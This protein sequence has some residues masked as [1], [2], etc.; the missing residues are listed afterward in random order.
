[1]KSKAAVCTYGVDG[2]FV[3]DSVF[4]IG[5]IVLKSSFLV[6]RPFAYSI[7]ILILEIG[8][9][10]NEAGGPVGGANGLVQVRDIRDFGATP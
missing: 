9:F 7:P 1:M 2:C 4:Q 10:G 5:G 3:R 6:G 8:D